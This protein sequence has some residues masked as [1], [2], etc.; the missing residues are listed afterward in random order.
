ML[1]DIQELLDRYTAW[2]KSGIN[3]RAIGDWVEITT[4]YV[5]R[6]NDQLQIYAKRENGHFLL[7][8][9]G[10]TMQ[11]LESSGC[12][13]GTP[14]RQELLKMTLNGFGVKLDYEQL[15]V[16]ATPENFPLKKHSLIQAM[17]AVNDLFYLAEPVVKSLFFEDVTAW[18]DLSDVRYT[19]K[20]KFTGLSGYDHLFDFVVPKSR[21]APERI[22]RAINR[23][24]RATAE[25]FIHAWSDTR[26]VRSPESQ[27]YAILND[28]D[29]AVPAEV[30]EALITYNIRPVLWSYREEVR[31]RL[32]A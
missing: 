25:T 12:N 29:Q 24:N 15:Q 20:V 18:L 8:D 31:E 4:P 30:P 26:E 17:L 27:A 14:K 13:P 28:S 22:L 16:T 10:H 11:D 23:P 9:D 21:R 5:D 3:L 1:S 32:A 7:T 19:P 6:H 2:L